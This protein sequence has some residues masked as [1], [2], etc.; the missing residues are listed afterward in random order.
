MLVINLTTAWDPGS[1]D[2]PN[3][4]PRC[5]VVSF[6]IK[7]VDGIIEFKYEYGD[8]VSGVWTP[9]A[10]SEETRR[11]LTDSDASA[12][13]DATSAG[14]GEKYSDEIIRD[15]YDWLIANVSECAGTVA[16]VS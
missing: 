8:V 11:Y 7:S 15:I 12:I 16:D 13:I 5:K 4:Y 14:A 1:K 2:S 10:F 3:T 6:N 9:G